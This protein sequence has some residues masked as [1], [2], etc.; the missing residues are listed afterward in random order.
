MPLELGEIYQMRYKIK[1]QKQIKN[2]LAEEFGEEKGHQLFD[3]EATTLSFII[4]QVTGKTKNQLKTLIQT[5]LPRI[6]MYKTFLNEKFSKDQANKYMRKYML[7]IIASKEHNSTAKMEK[8]PG[9]YY[10]YSSVFLSI[11]MTCF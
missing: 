3:K 9:F 4:E 8:F 7:E 1:Q 6:A 5:I 10:I 11:I 2:F